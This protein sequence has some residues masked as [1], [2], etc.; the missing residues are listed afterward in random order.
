VWILLPIN[1]QGPMNMVSKSTSILLS[2]IRQ[3]KQSRDVKEWARWELLSLTFTVTLLL[4]RWKF[5]L[6]LG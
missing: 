5:C 1:V 3:Q 6:Q 2:H 4:R